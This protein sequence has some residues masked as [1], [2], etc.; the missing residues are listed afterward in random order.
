[1]TDQKIHDMFENAKGFSEILG[2]RHVNANNKYLGNDYDPSQPSTN[3]LDV[4]ANNLYGDSLSQK[5]IY[6][7]WAAKSD[8]NSSACNVS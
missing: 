8:T 6:V 3:I 2:D 5:F 7:G 4:D 1:M